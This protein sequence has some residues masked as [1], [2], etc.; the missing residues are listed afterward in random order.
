MV[1]KITILK[2]GMSEVG[3]AMVSRRGYGEKVQLV[4]TFFDKSGAQIRGSQTIRAIRSPRAACHKAS[5]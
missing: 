5:S 3:E 4:W 2:T 1:R